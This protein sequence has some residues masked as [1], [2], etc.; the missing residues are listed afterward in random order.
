MVGDSKVLDITNITDIN[1]RVKA[2][3][4]LILS[5]KTFIKNRHKIKTGKRYLE[6]FNSKMY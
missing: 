5:A 1:K 6:I 3:R 2:E 4:I